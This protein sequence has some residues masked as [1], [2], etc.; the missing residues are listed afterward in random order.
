[1]VDNMLRNC[2]AWAEAVSDRVK[3]SEIGHQAVDNL[4]VLLYGIGLLSLTAWLII[5]AATIL[6]TPRVVRPGTPDLEK[7]A[8]RNGKPQ[9]PLGGV[10]SWSFGGQELIMQQYGSPCSLPVRR[11]LLTQ[12]GMWPRRNR[13][14]TGRLD[15]GHI[16]LPWD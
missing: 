7:P 8:S 14:H 6:K 1:M 4:K 9:R 15:M 16:T 2:Q 10:F 13:M 11:R 5:R 12:I 3:T